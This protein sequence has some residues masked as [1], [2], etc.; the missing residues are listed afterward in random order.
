MTL[1]KGDRWVIVLL[2]KDGWTIATIACGYAVPVPTVESV[3]RQ[4][5][6]DRPAQ[7]E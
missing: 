7:K 3:I 5:M 6:L 2:F 4:H 1:T